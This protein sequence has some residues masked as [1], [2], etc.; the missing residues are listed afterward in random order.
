VTG[1]VSRAAFLG[2]GPRRE[3]NLR[4]GDI[5][6]RDGRFSRGAGSPNPGGRPR[7]VGHV[8]DLAKLRTERAILGLD[9]I[10][11]VGDRVARQLI[12]EADRNGGKVNGDRNQAALMRA[13]V[14]AAELLDRGWG[15]PAQS[16]EVASRGAFVVVHRNHPPG[17]DPLN[18]LRK[19]EDRMVEMPAPSALPVQRVSGWVQEEDAESGTIE[20]GFCRAERPSWSSTCGTNEFR[21]YDRVRPGL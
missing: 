16:L 10:L 18:D 7:D 3:G 14:A 4:R 17:Y 6:G 20:S 9:H 13:G 5:R 1:L 19:H 12:A 8:K 21:I 15:R 11:E 2:S